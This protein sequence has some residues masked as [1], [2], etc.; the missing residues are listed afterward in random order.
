MLEDDIQSTDAS[1]LVKKNDYD[2][3]I[4]EIE[5]KKTNDHDHGKYIT[6][7]KVNKLTSD[8]FTVRLRQSNLASKNDIADLKKRKILMIN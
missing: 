6:T 8:N 1:I 5:K 4:S 7:Q 2:T 3:K